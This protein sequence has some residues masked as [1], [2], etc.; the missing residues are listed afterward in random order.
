[1]FKHEGLS[2]VLTDDPIELEDGNKEIHGEYNKPVA[3]AQLPYRQAFFR[4]VYGTLSAQLIY[5]FTVC[6]FVLK[7]KEGFLNFLLNGGGFLLAFGLIFSN[8]ALLIWRHKYPHNIISLF[9]FTTAASLN[10]AASILYVDLT[11][12]AQVQ[13]FIIFFI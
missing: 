1:M 7:N 2:Q 4:H 5:T 11:I 10:V 13:D 8:I 12:I 3:Y 9:I 6:A